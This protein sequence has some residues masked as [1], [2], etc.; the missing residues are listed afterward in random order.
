MDT[1]DGMKRDA[2][3]AVLMTA[4]GA[5]RIGRGHLFV[6]GDRGVQLAA[7]AA[8]AT[9]PQAL[10]DWHGS[11]DPLHLERGVSALASGRYQLRPETPHAATEDRTGDE[12]P[13]A[14]DLH[15]EVIDVTPLT[16]ADGELV[17]RLRSLD[18]MVPPGATELGGE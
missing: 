9:H 18:G 8:S 11:L 3:W 4:D 14:Q 6:E 17:A 5:Q 16:G 2:G 10:A 12:R 15:V 13:V 7:A 1:S